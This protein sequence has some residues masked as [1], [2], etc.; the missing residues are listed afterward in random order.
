MQLLYGL[1]TYV[2]NPKSSS[3]GPTNTILMV[4][5]IFG[6]YVNAKLLC[7]D[8][9]GQ[10]YRVLMPDLFEGDPVP[11]EMLNVRRISS[12]GHPASCRGC[13]IL[14]EG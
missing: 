6:L 8:W 5:D 14:K 11:I 2:S 13:S 12:Y 10:G 9:A 1:N 4:P 7:D 3:D